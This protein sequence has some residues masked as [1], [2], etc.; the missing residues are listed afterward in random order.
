MTKE[1]ISEPTYV[2]CPPGPIYFDLLNA[3]NEVVLISNRTMLTN[4]PVLQLPEESSPKGLRKVVEYSFKPMGSVS[5]SKL[6]GQDNVYNLMHAAHSQT[7]I[8]TIIRARIQGR[9]LSPQQTNI[10]NAFWDLTLL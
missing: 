7:R 9:P 5:L 6:V 3:A 8:D 10:F 1:V 4:L 2:Q